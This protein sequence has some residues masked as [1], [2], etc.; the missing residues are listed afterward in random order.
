MF[1]W[2]TWKHD[3]K[4][5]QY[6]IISKHCEIKHFKQ[7][8]QNIVKA[9]HMSAQST[10]D[11]KLVA[12]Q[13]STWKHNQKHDQYIIISKHCEIKHFKQILV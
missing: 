12:F 8:F 7:I 4:H 5:D 2:S 9:H 1:Q 11:Y 6:I 10:H 13:W 3:Q